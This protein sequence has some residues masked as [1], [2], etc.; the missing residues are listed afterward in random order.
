MLDVVPLFCT[1]AGRDASGLL[2]S[3][4]ALGLL[5][6]EIIKSLQNCVLKQQ[7]VPLSNSACIQ[8]VDTTEQQNINCHVQMDSCLSL[9]G[10]GLL[11]PLL[12]CADC[13]DRCSSS[14]SICILILC[15]ACLCL[16]SDSKTTSRTASRTL[17]EFRFAHQ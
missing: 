12:S 10:G 3:G 5:Q 2:F 15:R 6:D 13:F 1:R 9:K 14:S 16:L 11:L 17:H 4:S 8:Q 7:E